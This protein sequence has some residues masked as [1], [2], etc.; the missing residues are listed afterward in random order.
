R[1]LLA[2]ASGL[3]TALL[4]TTG[5]HAVELR[6]AVQTAG[7]T[8]PE[9]G[10]AVSNREGTEYERRQAQGLYGPRLNV[11]ASAGVR[12]LKNPTRRSL[13]IAD[14][15]LWPVELDATVDQLVT[16]FGKT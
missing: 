11:E 16:D 14:G 9:T 4:A 3:V 2:G 5:A 1:R 13:G 6:E 12:E 15:T 10:Q 8:N 7:T